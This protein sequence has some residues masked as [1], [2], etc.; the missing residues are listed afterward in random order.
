MATARGKKKLGALPKNERRQ[1]ILSVAREAFAKRGYHHATIDDIVAQA[2]V[3]RGTFYLYFIDKRAVFSELIDRFATQIGNA[4][5]RIVIDDP[6]RP[7]AD[8]VLDN[9]R[10]ILRTCLVERAMTKILFTDVVGAD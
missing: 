7:V 3:A 5:Q 8:Q 6:S 2:G 9:I 4:I 10:S 1:Q